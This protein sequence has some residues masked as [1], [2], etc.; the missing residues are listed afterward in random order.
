MYGST[1][2]SAWAAM[3]VDGPLEVL[4]FAEACFNSGPVGFR[5]FPNLPPPFRSGHGTSVAESAYRPGQPHAY[6]Q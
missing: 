6:Q 5:I 3:G 2:V 1:T 4:K